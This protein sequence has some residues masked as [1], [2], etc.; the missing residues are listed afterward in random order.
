MLPMAFSNY[1]LLT[2]SGRELTSTLSGRITAQNIISICMEF[3]LFQRL[4]VPCK[5]RQIVPAHRV[6]ICL[7]YL[8]CKSRMGPRDIAI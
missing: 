8:F 5:I 1:S 6:D 3:E 7:R 4:V 2:S